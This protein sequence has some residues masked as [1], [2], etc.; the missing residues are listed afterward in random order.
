[1]N[2]TDAGVCPYPAGDSSLAR[3]ALE[4]AELGFDSLVAIG[5]GTSSPPGPEVL[6]GTVIEAASIRDLLRQVRQ[7][8]VRRSDVV[9]V[10]AGDLSFNRSA[11]SIR[12]IH[13]IRNIHTAHRNAFDHVAARS[14]A[15]RGVA[16]DIAIAPLIYY[17]GTRRQRVLQCYADLLTLQR[18]Y[19]FPLTI[20]SN[21]RSFL[22]Q[23]SVREIRQL[24]ALFGMTQNEVGRALESVGRLIEP[25]RSVRVIE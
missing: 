1:M 21:A 14:A 6:F 7:P 17:R 23:R 3:M 24:C 19:G 4:A 5:G 9:Y 13:G 20:S 10:N 22:E 15:E 11:V 18:R 12:E 25:E 2:V 16:V 8:I